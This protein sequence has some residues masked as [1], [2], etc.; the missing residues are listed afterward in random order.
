MVAAFTGVSGLE[1]KLREIAE[2]V[3]KANSVRV[4]FLEGAT[5]PDGTPVPLVAALNNYGTENSPPRPFFSNMVSE[6]KGDWPQVLANVAKAADYDAELTL[7]RMG[8]VIGGQL[9][10]AIADFTT[11]VLADS[12]IARKGFAKPLVDKGVMQNSASYQVD[13]GEKV[14]VERT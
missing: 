8:E 9:L 12:T 2:K 13:D 3:G 5:Y 6:N 1:Q 11:P 7:G 4:G 14:K 10:D